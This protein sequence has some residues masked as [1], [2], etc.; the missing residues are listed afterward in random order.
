MSDELKQVLIKL[1]QYRDRVDHLGINLKQNEIETYKADIINE[2]DSLISDVAN[3]VDKST[4]PALHKHI[5]SQRGGQFSLKQL[6]IMAQKL[7]MSDFKQMVEEI[8]RL[9]CG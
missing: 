5:V 3:G 6:W 9:N 1:N 8:E 7:N 4:E 2:I